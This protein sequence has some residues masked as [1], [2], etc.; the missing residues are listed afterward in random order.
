MKRREFIT[1]LGGAAA[2]WPITAR[3]QQTDKMP[4]VGFLSGAS[5]DPFRRITAAFLKGLQETGYIENENI[6]IEYRWAESH[7]DRL[8]ALAADQ[9]SSELVAKRLGLLRDLIPAAK[10]IS[11]LVNSTDPRAECLLVPMR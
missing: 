11:S 8:P 6:K 7:Y 1:L 5:A 2:A 10:V 4:V 9:L 3:A